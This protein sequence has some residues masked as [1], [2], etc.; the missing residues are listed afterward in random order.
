[1]VQEVCYIHENRA[2][3]GG[4]RSAERDM[5]TTAVLTLA[6]LIPPP[7]ARLRLEIF[8]KISF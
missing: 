1:M 5:R 2:R 7:P 8:L 6:G 3:V 4:G